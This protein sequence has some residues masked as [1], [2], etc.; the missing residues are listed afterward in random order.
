M[1]G[2]SQTE[3]DL[4]GSPAPRLD[5][6][7]EEGSPAEQTVGKRKRTPRNP[8]D[9]ARAGVGSTH[10]A[11]R[12]TA[13]RFE[14]EGAGEITRKSLDQRQQNMFDLPAHRKKPGRDYKW[15]VFSIMGQRSEAASLLDAIE[16][17]WRDE[18]S[19]DWPELVVRGVGPNDP[20]ERYG[21]RLMGRP[22]HL[23]MEAQAET[24][25]KAK[26]QE[27]DRM[28]A[29]AGGQGLQ[30]GEGLANIRGVEVRGA[31]LD[32]QLSSGTGPRGR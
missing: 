13:P 23:S 19:G 14:A 27:R 22:I 21:Q 8:S 5:M 1:S 25:A 20:V 3:R 31:S 15:E 29:S 32:V 4:T 12:A 30:G 6:S 16:A 24:Y 7:T 28:Q 2:L 26:T 17:G 18:R 10:A 9:A 11:G